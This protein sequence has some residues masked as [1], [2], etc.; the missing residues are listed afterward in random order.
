MAFKFYID[1]QLTDQPVNDTALSTTISRDKSEGSLL[2]TQDATIIWNGNNNLPSG[3][4]S[5]FSYLKNLLDNGICNEAKIEI[6]DEVNQI[7]TDLIYVGVVKIPDMQVDLQRFLISCKV[8]DNSFYSYI[9][10]NKSIKVNLEATQTKEANILTPLTKFSVDLYNSNGC[11]YGSTFG[12]FYKGFLISEVFEFV[13]KAITNDR[14]GFSS[15]F[16]TNLTNP[17]ILFTGQSL[18]NPFSN[19]PNAQGI[20]EVTFE[21]LYNELNKL[22][23][24]SYYIDTSDPENPVFVLDSSDAIFQTTSSPYVF[25]DI[26]EMRQLV[27]TNRLYSLVKT[28]DDNVVFGGDP[29]YTFPR[30]VSF[31]GFNQEQFFPFGQ[32]NTRAELDLQSQ[33]AIDTNAIQ[34]AIVGNNEGLL[35]KIFLIECTNFDYIARTCEAVQYSLGSI[36]SCFYNLGLNN[37][38]KMQRH[39]TTFETAFGNFLGVG[40]DGFRA[41]LGDILLY[42]VNPNT[43]GIFIPNTSFPPFDP[44]VTT[45]PVVFTNET[46]DGN[47]DGNN[48]YLNTTG[49]YTVPTTGDYSF[50]FNADFIISGI[51]SSTA[52]LIRLTTRINHY[53]SANVLQSTNEFQ[54]F[55]TNNGTFT[56]STSL[57]VTA[58]A[59]DYVQSAIQVEVIALAINLNI[60]FQETS[61]FQCNGTPDGGISITSGN[62]NIKKYIYEFQYEL[63]ETDFNLI[64]SNPAQLLGFDKDGVTR[65]GWID[66]I[67]R[68]DW[69]G[70]SNIKL[71]TN[72]A[73]TTV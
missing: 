69:T 31:F 67:K 7:Q 28:G 43:A 1:G 32:C 46:T 24:L 71:I 9:N 66:T 11:V 5:G 53:N 72:N 36:G 50:A 39:S 26:K 65:Y 22:Y 21:Q 55:Y 34:D 29:W 62:R 47:Y 60:A 35:D 18:I 56:Q 8:S 41:G 23:N 63:N 13:I 73:I 14:V 15:D 52:Y 16:L 17:L 4:I 38:N 57:V 42:S 25:T 6:Y 70:V 68:D 45:E 30:G 49:V 20:F 37:F 10:N 2:V 54:Q 27:D 44:G 59:T 64:R 51:V 58:D 48:N 3:T 40:G 12:F 61:N 19:F 33:Y